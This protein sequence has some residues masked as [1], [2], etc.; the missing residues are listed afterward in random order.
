M[1]LGGRLAVTFKNKFIFMD[2]DAQPMVL[3]EAWQTDLV[4][5]EH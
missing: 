5:A 3:C 2:E 1:R 4:K